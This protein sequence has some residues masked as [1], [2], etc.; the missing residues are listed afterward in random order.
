MFD[1]YLYDANYPHETSLM[2]WQHPRIKESKW[3][4]I[5]LGNNYWQLKSYREK[6]IKGNEVHGTPDNWQILKS[7]VEKAS[8]GW[9]ISDWL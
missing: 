2:L 9:K 1:E 6:Y 4:A 3:N 5:D 8:P 7:K